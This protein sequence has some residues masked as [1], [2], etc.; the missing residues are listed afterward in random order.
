MTVTW[1]EHGTRL[2]PGLVEVA[3]NQL[4]NSTMIAMAGVVAAGRPIEASTERD[5]RSSS[6]DV[7]SGTRRTF[8]LTGQR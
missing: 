1:Y 7:E 2:V 5:C 3:V 6:L 4:S 8:R